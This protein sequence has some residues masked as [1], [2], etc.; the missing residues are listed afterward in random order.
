MKV[1]FTRRSI[2]IYPENEI[3]KAY[4]EDTLGL[5]QAGDFLRLK[6]ISV[7]ELP[8]TIAY[9]ETSFEKAV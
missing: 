3:D 8:L 4:I 5:K 2:K 1:E 6:R 7:S 9:L